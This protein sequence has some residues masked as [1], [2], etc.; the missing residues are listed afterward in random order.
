MD[1][2]DLGVLSFAQNLEDVVLS[3]L[4]A[5][6]PVGTYVDVGAGHPVLE[7]VTYALYRADWRGINV[8]PM[9]PEAKLL[10]A[11][12]P[13]DLTL[14][15]ACGSVPGMVTLYEAPEE[16]RGATTANKDLVAGYAASGQAFRAFEAEVVTL[17]SLLDMYEPGAVHVVKIDVEGMEAEVIKGAELAR[18]RPW[19]LVIEATRPNTSEDSSTGWEPAVLAA[20][21][22]MTLFDGL[23][24]FYVRADLSEVQRLLSVPANVFDRWQRASE[25]R[26]A[27]VVDAQKRELA[28][29]DAELTR[30]HDAFERQHAE[31]ERLHAEI[32][33]L[34]AEIQRLHSDAAASIASIERE[35][36]SVEDYA[37]SLEV[38]REQ[39]RSKCA[40]LEASVVALEEKLAQF[41]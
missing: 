32:E 14:Q 36:R 13:S 16:N 2:R 37:H 24:R 19:V 26:A 17:A 39:I 6:V 41:R 11:E 18:T 1:V 15:V 29:Q 3:R 5:L 10:R 31:I 34:H 9:A 12:R 27:E 20:G 28:Q 23:N 7:N 21:Y 25:A 22:A 38:D 4:L 30:L 35:F 40:A 33:R 8:E